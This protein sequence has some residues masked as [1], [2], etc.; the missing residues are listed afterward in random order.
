MKQIKFL[1]GSLAELRD[2]PEAAR[3]EAG[4]QLHK[5]QLGLEPSD[6]KPMAT[7]GPGVREVRIG[8]AAGAF[9]VLYVTNIGDA[10]YVLHAFENK[11]QQ[12][13]KRHLDLAMLRLKQI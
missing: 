13:A 6:W 12:T 9:R 7:V 8:D 2:F 10:V 5:I 11:T 1:G 4:I 3:K